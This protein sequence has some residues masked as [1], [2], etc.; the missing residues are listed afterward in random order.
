[1]VSSVSYRSLNESYNQ[2]VKAK[3]KVLA[4]NGQSDKANACGP[5]FPDTLKPFER[6]KEGLDTCF[7]QLEAQQW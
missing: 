5:K 1:M 2:K 6:P 3:R 4:V 7:H